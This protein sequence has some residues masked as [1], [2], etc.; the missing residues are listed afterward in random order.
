[1]SKLATRARILKFLNKHPCDLLVLATHARE[2][3]PRWLRGSVG[4]ELSRKASLPALFLP[5]AS[6]GFVSI[7]SGEVQLRNVLIPI[8]HSPSPSVAV[9]L[10]IN[11]AEGLQAR[12]TVFHL[13]HVGA[14]GP[15]MHLDARHEPQLRRLERDGPTVETIVDAAGEVD[16]DLVVMATQGHD[17]FLD[18]FRGS[19]TEQVLRRSGRAVLAVP[20]AE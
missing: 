14:D 20:A 5:H 2:G 4:E 15:T 12:E 16:A 1:M 11:L 7:D 13:L 10:A 17:G 19:T 9:S 8:D 3:L 18:A 6:R